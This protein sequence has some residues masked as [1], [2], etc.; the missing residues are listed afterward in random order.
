MKA[1]ILFY[2]YYLFGDAAN[3]NFIKKCL[4]ESE[5]IFT[6]IHDKPY[7]ADSEPDL[8]YMGAMSESN[9][10]R[11]IEFLAPYKD[12]LNELIEKGVHFLFTSNACDILGNYIIDNGEKTQCLGLFDFYVER[13]ML[14]R[15]NG[16]V[17]GNYDGIDIV[18]FK[19]Q[20]GLAYPGESFDENEKLFDVTRGTGLNP[21]CKY[22]GLK[23]N[24]L[25]ATYIIGPFLIINP[26]FTKRW[27]SEITGKEVVLP[28]EKDAFTAYELRLGEF[29][30]ENRKI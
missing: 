10:V 22:E 30:D 3:V 4:P 29:K 9:Q 8:I 13:K 15:F 11:A 23:R 1:E 2:D 21:D 5:F 7:F 18:G 20:F 27:L 12:R 26:L 19:S 25:I 14:K 17:L 28:F 24:N 16:A 6:G